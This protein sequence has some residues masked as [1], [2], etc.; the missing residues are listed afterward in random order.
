MVE[1]VM[2]ALISRDILA[3]KRE[4]KNFL[5]PMAKVFR[6]VFKGTVKTKNVR[7]GGIL[8]ADIFFIKGFAGF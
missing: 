8:F 1:S 2:S 4:R 5:A 7:E 3:S 6:H